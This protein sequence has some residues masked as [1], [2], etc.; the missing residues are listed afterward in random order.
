M[1]FIAVTTR[2]L[3]FMI[4]VTV[5]PGLPPYPTFPS[6]PFSVKPARDLEGVLALNQ[7][8]N[9][10]EHLLENK[11]IAPES[12][13]VRGNATFVSTYGGKIIE[14]TNNDQ[15]RIVAKFGKPCRSSYDERE[16]GRPLGMAFDTQ[17][18]NLIVAEPYSGIWQ[19]Q[20]KTGA[21]MLLVSENTIIDGGKVSRPLKTP[22][23]VAVDKNGDIFWSDTV[24]DVT[25]DNALIG[26]LMNPSGRL[27]Q[28][29]RSTGKS[30]VLIDEVYGANGVALS[31]DEGFVLVGELGGQQ[32]RR[33]Y[34]KGPKAGTD[35]IFI[36]GL[37]G[38]V[39]NLVSD[40]SGVWVALAIAVDKQNPSPLALLAPYPNVRRFCVRMMTIL[41]LSFEFIYEKTGSLLALR[42]SNFIG[43][44]SSLKAFISDRGSILRLDWEGNIVAA[45]FSDD[46]SA[47][48]I[49]HAV[50]SGDYLLLG[51]PIHPWMGRV[52]LSQEVLQIVSTG[53]K[54]MGKLKPEVIVDTKKQKLISKQ[55]L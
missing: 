45:L 4:A 34:L 48:L 15:L 29:N 17:G 53:S 25:F 30:R 24:S 5:L 51:S 39:D 13:L 27:L 3:I 49:S 50:Q 10:A 9:N 6:R 18:N 8:L 21:K 38:A 47:N 28:H 32:I 40:E 23:G 7:L 31:K 2:I 43:N 46:G 12:I 1:G 55:E 14:I 41:D 52:R 37:P 26:L 16:C 33:Y 44:L 22:N 36:D 42:I 35:D 19:I 54:N 20:I 11:L